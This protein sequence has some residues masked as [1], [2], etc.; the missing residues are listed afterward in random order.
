MKCLHVDLH[1][2]EENIENVNIIQSANTLIEEQSLQYI[3]GYIVK[4]FQ[5]NTHI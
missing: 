4:K 2:N 1:E 3:G 5:R